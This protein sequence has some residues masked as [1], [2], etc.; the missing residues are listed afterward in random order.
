MK[1]IGLNEMAQIILGVSTCVLCGRVIKKDFVGFPAFLP[2]THR[3]G[4]YS[5]GVFHR[6]CFYAWKDHEE[7][8]GLYN[9]FCEIW[10]SRPSE[11]KTPEGIDEWGRKALI[12]FF[13]EGE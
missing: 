6:K 1:S 8:L 12:E 9:R 4:E 13:D 7:F 2:V 5:D 3:F 11:L 10:D